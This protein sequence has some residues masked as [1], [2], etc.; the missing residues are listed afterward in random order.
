VLC[1]RHSKGEA[2]KN[3]NREI[4][5]T[6]LS[7]RSALASPPQTIKKIRTFLFKAKRRT[8]S[9]LFKKDEFDVLRDGP[10]IKL[11]AHGGHRRLAGNTVGCLF[12]PFSGPL[13]G[14][15]PD[16]LG[17]GAT[18][19][20]GADILKFVVGEMLDADE[21]VLRRADPD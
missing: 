6:R 1:S 16:L 12:G 3:L 20:L 14:C 18:F 5:N 9:T 19:T 21:R 13:D 7:R 11:R 15:L 17:F 4:I 10:A 8:R 2:C